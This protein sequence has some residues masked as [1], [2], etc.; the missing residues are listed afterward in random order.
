[1]RYHVP[2]HI[3]LCLSFPVLANRVALVTGSTSGI[4]LSIAHGLA[5]RGCRIVLNG[6]GDDKLISSIQSDFERLFILSLS[7]NLIRR[8]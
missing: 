5:S 8:S 1:M 4:G 6:F 7:Y 3:I 2:P